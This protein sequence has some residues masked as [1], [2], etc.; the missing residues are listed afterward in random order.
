MDLFDPR[1]LAVDAFYLVFNGRLYG[2]LVA[3]IVGWTA[4]RADSGLAL[5][6]LLPEQGALAAQPFLVQALAYLVVRDF[7]EWCVHN[8]LH[9]VPFLWQFRKVHHSIHEMDWIGH[10]R[11]HWI[12]SVVYRSLTYVPLLWLG[13]GYEPL[14]L[15]WVF[16]TIWGHFNHANVDLSLGPLG[17]VFNSPR[18]HLWHHDASDEGGLAK[19]FGLVFSLWDHLFGTAYWP[20]ARAH[21][22]SR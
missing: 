17:Y 19:N 1:K 12:E 20:R 3:G 5:V 8:L 7:L 18:M 14:L 9:R 13:G 15:C 21:R 4:A 11:F 22:L 10:F 2:M 6:S 16:A